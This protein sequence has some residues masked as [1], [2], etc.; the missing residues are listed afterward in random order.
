MI[1]DS[2]MGRAEQ[3]LD[4]AHRKSCRVT[5]TNEGN[6]MVAMFYYHVDYRRYDSLPE[7]VG[8]FHAYYRQERP[9][10][11]DKITHSSTLKARDNMSAQ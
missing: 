1:R 5:V 9:R 8:Y 2:S 4:D 11:R 3:L 7:D 10:A 6:R